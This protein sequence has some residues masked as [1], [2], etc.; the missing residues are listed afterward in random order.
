MASVN[1]ERRTKRW[2][3]QR[4]ILDSIIRTVGPEWDQGRIES[5]SKTGGPAAEGDYKS[6]ARRMRKFDDIHREFASAAK[7][8]EAKARDFE[9]QGRGV[10]AR[11]S[12]MAAAML[13]ASA[14]WP[15]FEEGEQLS[16][17]EERMNACYAKFIKFAPH[18]IQRVDIPFGG[19]KYLPAYLHLP[20]KPEK[21][22]KFPIVFYC[23]GMDGSK[24]NMVSLYGDRFI[25]RG[26]AVLAIDG[27][28]QAEA[29]SRGIYFSPENWQKCANAVYEFLGGQSAIDIEKLV[30]R[31]SSFGSFWGTVAAA[32]LG[33]KV[34]GYV[35]TG[36]CQ[37]PGAWQIF[38]M[39][40]PTFKVRFM[41]MSGYDDEDEFDRFCKTI[42]LTPYMPK[43]KCPYSVIT[44]ENEQLSPLE[45][46]EKLFELL[47]VPKRMVVFE[48][49][50]H[51]V[52]GA[53]SAENGEDRNTM[54]ADWLL[55]RVKG[56]PAKSERVWID[57]SG[58]AHSEPFPMPKR[59]SAKA[60]RNRRR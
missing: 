59:P 26:F 34:K 29:V 14:C 9:H 38:N 52:T 21:G 37:E 22:E 12:Y 43:I 32:T 30:I 36:L 11:E 4:W 2:Q 41:F 3:Q 50:N 19:G 6:A 42:D 16:G 54:L 53:P 58:R 44:G 5:R 18:P 25:E 28:G 10:A 35:T 46:T 49:A 13:W 57:S 1:V 40:S 23:G 8:R 17:Y 31:G 47:K 7:K 20:R 48:G 60:T 45:Y 56:K 55:D 24:E 33:N 15:I 51:S 39:A 27:P